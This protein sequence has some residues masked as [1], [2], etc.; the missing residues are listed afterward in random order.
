MRT[1]PPRCLPSAELLRARGL[2]L[3]EILIVVTI[4]SAMATI[5][6]PSLIKAIDRSRQSST[7]ADMRTIGSA[8]ERY[9]V[10]HLSY[11]TV[12]DTLDLRPALEPEYVKQLPSIDG[13][14]HPFVFEVDDQGSSYTLRSPGKD[15]TLQT[16]API[17]TTRDVTADIVM[18]DGV[19]V[20][21]PA[22]KQAETNGAAEQPTASQS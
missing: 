8:L 18:V 22:G 19:F 7:M 2:S 5:A 12:T 9:A 11:P 10:D 15:G 14:G 20:Q 21:R 4:I 13:W 16:A 3:L 6:I 17:E 1:T